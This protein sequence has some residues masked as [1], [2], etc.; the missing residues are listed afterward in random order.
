[1]IRNVLIFFMLSGILLVGMWTKS[2]RQENHGLQQRIKELEAAMATDRSNYDK[3]YYDYIREENELRH[4]SDSQSETLANLQ[5]QLAA[6]KQKL[7]SLQANLAQLKNAG[8]PG[9]ATDDHISDANAAIAQIQA[10]LARLNDDGTTVVQR[11]REYRQVQDLRQKEQRARVDSQ[12]EYVNASIPRVQ[13]QLQEVNHRRKDASSV[14][15]AQDLKNQLIELRGQQVQLRVQRDQL[16]LA[17]KNTNSAIGSEV[18]R[19]QE[20]I[21]ADREQ[22]QHKLDQAKAD[23]ENWKKQKT[24]QAGDPQ[25][26]KI[27]ATEQEITQAAASVALLERMVRALGQPS[28]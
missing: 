25:D 5:D 2:L 17:A 7:Q 10:Q 20:E 1:M 16:G 6:A 22:A 14:V 18:H 4:G 26:A 27:K 15:I 28:N 13:A 9:K 12:I 8:N 19:E 24:T 23:L 3:L 21:K 11:S